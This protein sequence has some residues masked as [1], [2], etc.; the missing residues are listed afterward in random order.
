MLAKHDSPPGLSKH[1]PVPVCTCHAKLVG[2]DMSRANIST[3][4]FRATN[5]VRG[6]RSAILVV[7]PYSL[8]PT[9]P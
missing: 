6:S 1:G 9:S 5:I 8:A 2:K 4:W 3:F 7:H